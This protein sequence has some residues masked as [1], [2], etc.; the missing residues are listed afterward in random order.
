MTSKQQI[1]ILEYL[2]DF[3]ATR[4]AIAA[5]YSEKSA[6][7]IGSQLLANP[8]IKQAI[9]TALNERKNSLIADRYERMIFLTNTMRDNEEN[10]KYRIKAA[11][12]LSKLDGDMLQ[13]I[14]VK[15]EG[16]TLAEFLLQLN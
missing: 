6:R 14:E 16:S 10:I 8:E 4:S 12:I 13:K 3:N 11:E 7:I 1:F 2:L 15:N 9:N 5:G